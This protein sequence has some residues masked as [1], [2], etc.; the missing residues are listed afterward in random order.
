[1]KAKEADERV[2]KREV[3]VAGMGSE[4]KAIQDKEKPI[5]AMKTSKREITVARKLM[6]M[7]GT[8]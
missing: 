1:M 2:R 7:K 3:S 4:L 8:V 5:E 6:R